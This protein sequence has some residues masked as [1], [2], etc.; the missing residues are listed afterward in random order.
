[1]DRDIAHCAN[2]RLNSDFADE[3][4]VAETPSGHHEG[5]SRHPE[6][7]RVIREIRDIAVQ[8][9]RSALAPGARRAQNVPLVEMR[10]YP[11]LHSTNLTP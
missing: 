9:L 8:P 2:Q 11:H 7:I 5:R 10:R 4:D 1:M 6:P 3:A